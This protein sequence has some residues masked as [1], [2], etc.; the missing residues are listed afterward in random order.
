METANGSMRTV[1][2]L[3]RWHVDRMFTW[4]RER[5]PGM[6][7]QADE[8]RGPPDYARSNRE[9][10]RLLLEAFREGRNSG[11]GPGSVNGSRYSWVRDVAIAVLLAMSGW[12]LLQ[13]IQQ[14]KDIVRMQCQLSPTT[15]M[16]VVPRG[17]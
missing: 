17:Q 13:V 1:H 3:V 6:T 5:L 7:S 4:V 10:S 9:L 16:Q 8:D 15:C 2:V 12:T 14:G 11:P